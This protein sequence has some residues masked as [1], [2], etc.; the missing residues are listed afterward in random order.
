MRL[1][2]DRARAGLVRRA[3]LKQSKALRWRRSAC[4]ARSSRGSAQRS[5]SSAL[6]APRARALGV[7]PR[8]DP[9]R[10]GRRSS[11]SRR[12]TRPT[13]MARFDELV[14]D[15]R[16]RRDELLAWVET[17]RRDELYAGPLP[18]DDHERLLRPQGPVRLRPRRLGARSA[19]SSCATRRG[20]A[21]ARACRA[22]A[23]AMLRR[24]L[25]DPHEHAGR[26]DAATSASTACSALPVNAAGR[27]AGRSAQPL[28][29]AVPQR[30][31]VGRDA[32]RG[33][34]GGRPPAARR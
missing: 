1:G 3:R 24:R 5:A 32:A 33:G 31:P 8:A 34:A 13:M 21:C 17:R 23:L 7:L 6:L 22:G 28:P 2:Y 20:W 27:G 30:L 14:T 10:P 29:A 25:A 18:R 15:P 19:A 11:A 12:S 16:L 4:R 26:G 9:G